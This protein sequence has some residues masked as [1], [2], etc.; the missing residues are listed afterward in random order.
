[1]SKSN[2]NTSLLVLIPLGSISAAGELPGFYMPRAGKIKSVALINNA[3]IA[4]SNTDYATVT[5]QN[6]SNVIGSV[7]TRAANQGAV[8]AK[9]AKVGAM[10]SANQAQAA[11]ASL[12]VVYAESG[13]MALTSA[14]LQV[15]VSI[16]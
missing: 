7:D 3:D 16:A 12:K 6:G 5:L 15:E 14:L 13:T 2:E 9:V 10:T 1:M 11:G 8:T 4:A